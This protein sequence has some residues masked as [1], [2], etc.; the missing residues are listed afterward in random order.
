MAFISSGGKVIAFAEYSDITDAD[1]RLFEANEGLAN[2]TEI[3][4]L[5]ERSTTRILQM[6]KNTSWWQ[7]YYLTQATS[8]Q[9]NQTQTLGRPDFPLPDATLIRSRQ[10]DFTDLCVYY[11]FSQYL[12]PRVADFGNA[13]SAEVKKI[14]FYD[15]R[16]R[17]L[18]AELIESGDWYDWDASGV[19]TNLERLPTRVNLVRP[20]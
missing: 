11:T 12:L 5:T 6:I 3:E 15:E 19:I 1:Q 4:L 14:G 13:D 20:R 8:G 9:L 16:F 7:Q 10:S 2:E 18:F 17:R